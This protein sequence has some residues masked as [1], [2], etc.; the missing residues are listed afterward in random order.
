MLRS[1]WVAFENLLRAVKPTV[2]QMPRGYVTVDASSLSGYASGAHVP[3]I[4]GLRVTRLSTLADGKY[5][6]YDSAGSTI[7]SN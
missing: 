2:T 1:E 5:V 4:M 3:D 6:Y 7:A